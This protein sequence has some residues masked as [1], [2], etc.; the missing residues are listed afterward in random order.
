MML[1]ISPVITL[2]QDLG[3][4]PRRCAV[5]LPTAPQGWVKCKDHITLYAVNVT[6]KTLRKS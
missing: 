5:A 6:N 4:V 1:G 3:S 2:G